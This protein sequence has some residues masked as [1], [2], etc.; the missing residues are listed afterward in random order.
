MHERIVLTEYILN[1]LN[2]SFY[3]QLYMRSVNHTLN[4]VESQ[5]IAQKESHEWTDFFLPE[6]QQSLQIYK[7]KQP[8]T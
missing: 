7:E 3:W 5:F 8:T 2:L 4:L 6:L 1:Y